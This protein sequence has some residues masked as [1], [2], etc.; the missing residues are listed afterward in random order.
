MKDHIEP[1]RCWGCGTAVPKCGGICMDCS[2]EAHLAYIAH[3][4]A[5]DHPEPGTPAC[6]VGTWEA[7]R[8]A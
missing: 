3:T 8:V 5:F 4:G 1:H 6:C 7:E 2:Y